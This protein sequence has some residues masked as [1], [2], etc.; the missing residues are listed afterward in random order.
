MGDVQGFLALTKTGD[1]R[2]KV[3]QIVDAVVLKKDARAVQLSCA[4][5]DMA[6][7]QLQ[8][9]MS[10]VTI[11]RLLPGAQVKCTVQQAVP[12]GLRVTFMG[13]LGAVIEA[14]HLPH[15]ATTA[16]MTDSPHGPLSL[17]VVY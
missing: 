15:V 12:N 6:T 1:Q 3:G 4:P 9:N 2:L 11:D 14:A 16:G 5:A 8:A 10:G 7:S 13:G 17:V